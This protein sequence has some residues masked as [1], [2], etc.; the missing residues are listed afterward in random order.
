MDVLLQDLRFALR[1]LRR[2]PA[3]TAV[4]VT[5]MAL[6]IGV[7]TMVF[8]IVYAVLFRP[9]AVPEPERLVLIQQFEPK[10]DAHDGFEVSALNFQDFRRGMKSV[11]AMGAYWDHNAFVTIDKEAER[12]FAATVTYDLFDALGVKPILGHG[13]APEEDELGRNWTNVLISHKVWTE[14]YHSDPN[15]LGKTLRINGRTRTIIG[16]MPAGFRWPEIQ[17][18]WIPLGFDPKETRGDYSLTVVGRLKPG[19]TAA[20]ADAEVRTIMA[21]IAKDNPK[22]SEGI[23]ASAKPLRETMIND[24]RPMMLMLLAA[25]VFVLLIACAN[26][27]NLMLARAASR[28]R[29]ISMRLALG[30][31]RGR[32]VRQLLTE[33]VVIAV[34]GAGLGVLLAHWGNT[35]WIATIPL[36]LPM[37]LDFSIDTPILLYTI[38]ISVLAGLLFGFAPAL[39]ATDTHLVE[40]LREGSAQAGS[41]HARNRLRASLVVAEIAMSLVLLVG[42]GLMLRSFLKMTE[43][44]KTI[45]TDGLLTGAVLL[46][47]ATYPEEQ[48][49]VEFFHAVLPQIATIPGVIEASMVQTLP[50]NRGRWG[51]RMLAE[52]TKYTDP[53]Q[54]PNVNYG[55]VAPDY[56]HVIG[57]P[58]LKGRDFNSADGAKSQRVAIVSQSLAKQFWGAEDPIG[59]RLKFAGEADSLGWALVVGVVGDVVQN[60]DDH[61]RTLS[62]CYVPHDQNPVQWMTFVVRAPAGPGGIAAKI[63]EIIHARNPDLALVDVRTMEEHIHFAMWQNRLFMSL[64]TTFAI[65][66]L[67]IAGVG[68]YGVMAYNV[69]QRTQEI[70]IRMALGA[71]R[72]AVV[73]MVVGQA[74]RLTVIGAGIGLAA[75]YA[76]TRVM[77]SVLFNVSPNDPPTYAGVALILAVSSILAAWLPAHRATRVDP[78]VAL[79]YE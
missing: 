19:A 3:Y 56:F 54:A 41:G 46:P 10:R 12:L 66:A 62:H 40:A 31:T 61:Q 18:F 6:G 36:E 67:L 34:A 50:I 52:G 21:G 68:I 22:T 73:R 23:S 74:M 38:G 25:V 26:V 7:N 49:K 76:L 28:R 27:A 45:H 4:V 8:S 58:L 30:A 64:F 55:I 42:A 51:Q 78:M 11:E 43:L 15:V 39:H 13:F 59:R 47:V 48:D 70:G 1:A 33:S 2:S 72:Q 63:R 35:L 69:A 75:A 32:V 57:I 79:R 5:V 44:R 24:I 16:V 14:R 17:D 9:L 37:W 20:Q 71:D 60:P 29:E 53:K 65:L 77:A